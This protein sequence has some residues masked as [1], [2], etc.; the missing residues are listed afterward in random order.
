MGDAV[1]V[2]VWVMVVDRV[3]VVVLDPVVEGE[4]DPEADRVLVVESE[5]D[6]VTVPLLDDDTVNV[7]DNVG[8]V[9]VVPVVESVTVGVRE[10]EGVTDDDALTDGDTD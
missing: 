6:D 1:T 2:T 8:D 7:A 5:G 10:C 9:V 4:T 3:P